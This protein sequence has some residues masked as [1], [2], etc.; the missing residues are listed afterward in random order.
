MV[1]D[2]FKKLPFPLKHLPKLP[3]PYNIFM[4]NIIKVSYAI[5]VFHVKKHLLK[6]QVLYTFVLKTTN[7]FYNI[8]FRNYQ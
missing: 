3:K 2:F 4:T 5:Q 6:K 8:D 7:K 1:Y